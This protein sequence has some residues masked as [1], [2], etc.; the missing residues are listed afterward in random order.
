M[1]IPVFEMEMASAWHWTY[2][3][4]FQW[5]CRFSPKSQCLVTADQA[6]LPGVG[7]NCDQQGSSPRA[8]LLHCTTEWLTPAISPNV[9]NS[10]AQFL[11]VGICVRANPFYHYLVI[12]IAARSRWDGPTKF[13]SL[14]KVVVFWELASENDFNLFLN[15]DFA[16]K[17]LLKWLH[18][19]SR[20]FSN[21]YE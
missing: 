20:R 1:G 17:M 18:L 7:V 2:I 6:Y 14:T 8:R 9:G 21:L 19:N 11:L 15:W 13:V 12:E 16:R 4:Y 10:G 5:H 3:S